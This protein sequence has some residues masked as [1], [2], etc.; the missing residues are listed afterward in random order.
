MGTSHEA[1]QTASAM[2]DAASRL[3]AALTDAQRDRIGAAVAGEQRRRDWSFLPVL[4][5]DGLLIGDLDDAQRKLAH[6]L[7]V[8]GTSMPGYA[9]VVS[10]MAMEHVLRALAAARRPAAANLFDP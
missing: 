6:E 1:P 2:A 8:A 4:E 10:V 7:I 3:L 5:R 9:K